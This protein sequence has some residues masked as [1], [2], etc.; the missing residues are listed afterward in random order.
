MRT[1]AAVFFFLLFAAAHSGT[2]VDFETPNNQPMEITSTGETRYENGVAIARG[3]VAIHLGDTDIYADS[4]RYDS[5]RHE[6]SAEGH[7]RIYR[8]DKLYLAER[9]TYNVDTKEIHAET[10]RSASDPYF[11]TGQKLGDF[12]DGRSIVENGDFTTADSTDPDFHFHAHKVRIYRK[13]SRR[14]PECDFLHWKSSCFLVALSLS[15]I[16]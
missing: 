7:V 15:I 5:Q 2:A 16:K 8:E 14:F 10:L 12:S 11:V 4:A 3:N 9:G 13:R 6:V 1:R